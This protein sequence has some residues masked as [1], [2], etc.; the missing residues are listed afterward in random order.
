MTPHIREARLSDAGVLLEL[1]QQH[2]AF[3]QAT[4]SITKPMLVDILAAE[5]PPTRICV[6]ESPQVLLGY[7]AVTFDYA[8]WSAERFAHLDCLFVHENARG[9]GVGG[10]LFRYI[11]RTVHAAA[12]KRM[13][14]QTPAWNDD[15]IRFYVREGGSGRHKMRFSIIL[16]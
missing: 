1:I 12:V 14:W 3:E 5:C 2:A 8:L 11:C 15:A 13:E 16:P 6:A 10:R 7:A 4:A 9:Q